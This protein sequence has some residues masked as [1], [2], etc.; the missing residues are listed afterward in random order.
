MASSPIMHGLLLNRLSP[1]FY[2]DEVTIQQYTATQSTSGEEVKTWANLANH[3]DLACAV[4]AWHGREIKRPDGI[5]AV[6]PWR[7]AVAGHHPDILP[8]MRAVVTGGDTYD[9][10]VVQVDSHANMTAL[11]CEIVT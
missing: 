5:I 11:E 1:R 4:A 8:K 3:V 9:I 6:S 10:L 7:I 2:P